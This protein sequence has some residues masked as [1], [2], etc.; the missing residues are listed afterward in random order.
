MSLITRLLLAGFTPRQ[1]VGTAGS[2]LAQVSSVDQFPFAI[3][4]PPRSAGLASLPI[5]P[6]QE[7]IRSKPRV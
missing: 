1:P 3:S 7:L 6:M 4:G 5:E 2:I